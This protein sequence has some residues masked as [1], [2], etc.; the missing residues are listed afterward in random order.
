MTTAPEGYGFRARV[1]RTRPGMT[2]TKL[3]SCS[4][5]IVLTFKKLVPDSG[6][7]LMGEKLVLV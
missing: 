1:L 3:F 6:G 2:P 7:Q 5:I 4:S